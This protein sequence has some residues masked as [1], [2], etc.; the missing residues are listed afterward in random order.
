MVNMDTESLHN[1]LS[2]LGCLYSLNRNINDLDSQIGSLDKSSL[3]KPYNPRK[4]NNRFGI[5]LT[6]LDG[7]ASGEINLD[8]IFE[9]NKENGTNYNELSFRVKTTF[10]ENNEALKNLI[11]PWENYLGRSHVIKLN[12]GGFFPWHRDSYGL[13]AD[14]FRLISFLPSS[15]YSM[16]VLLDGEI[17]KYQPGQLYFMD[18]AKEH[19]LF[20][21]CDNQYVIVFNVET[22][23]ETVRSV[24]SQ[25]E[26]R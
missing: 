15:Q 3:W 26:A 9:Y 11:H 7:G 24:F 21:F 1:K 17:L 16:V 8:S 14:S 13:V 18:T 23:K 2:R 5:S 22:N 10:F 25:L 12:T 19:C 20:S 4:E 6:S